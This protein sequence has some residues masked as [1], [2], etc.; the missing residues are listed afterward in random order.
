MAQYLPALG[1]ARPPTVLNQHEPGA[2]AASDRSRLGLMPG[3]VAPWL[4]VRAW[5]KYEQSLARHVDAIVTFTERDREAMEALHPS[6]KLKVI[7][8]GAFVPHVPANPLGGQPPAILF[9][10][11][12][13]HAP[14]FDAALAPCA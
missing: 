2:A 6:G 12:Y 10:G 5:R 7:A 13:L 4:E 11:N 3:R 8:L 14:N 1:P 9:F